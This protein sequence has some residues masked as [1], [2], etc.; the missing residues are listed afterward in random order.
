[1]SRLADRVAD[2]RFSHEYAAKLI[3]SVPHAEW[4]MMPGGVSSVAWQ[5]G[6]LAMAMSRMVLSRACGL[7]TDG[8]GVLP[9]EYLT[10][11]GRSSTPLTVG[12][13]DPAQLRGVFQ[14]VYERAIAELAARPHLDL[15]S[16]AL[17]SHTF[18]RTVDDCL[19]WASHHEMLHAGQIAL[20]RRQLGHQPLW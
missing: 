5:V 11:F 15:D 9:A 13:L 4:A 1:M 12:P 16:P 8:G 6:H 2:L 17:G 14:G 20:L 18:C 19:R 10:A 7:E 3:D